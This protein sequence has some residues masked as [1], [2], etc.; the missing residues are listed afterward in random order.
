MR[1]I[2]FMGVWIIIMMRKKKLVKSILVLIMLLLF[3]CVTGI[4]I[5]QESDNDDAEDSYYD[6]A[7]KNPLK[8]GTYTVKYYKEI[9]R[10][11]MTGR[12]PLEDDEL[13]KQQSYYVFYY[14][15]SIYQEKLMIERYERF[16][17]NTYSIIQRF[18]F[19]YMGNL[20]REQTFN[21]TGKLKDFTIYEYT[22]DGRLS[23]EAKYSGKGKYSDPQSPKSEKKI[24]YTNGKIFKVEYFSKG[25]LTRREM[26]KNNNI[27]K[28]FVYYYFPNGAK[29][30]MEEFD[31]N[32][33]IVKLV[34][35]GDNGRP[36][37][38]IY[39]NKEGKER[40]VV[41]MQPP[42]EDETDSLTRE[43][44]LNS[45]DSKSYGKGM[46]PGIVVLHSMLEILNGYMGVETEK[47]KIGDK[48][49]KN[50][51]YT[52]IFG[53]FESQ[54]ININDELSELAGIELA[55]EDRLY[56]LWQ[57]F[58]NFGWTITTSLRGAIRKG[59]LI[60]FDYVND[61][62]KNG[63]LKD[64]PLSHVAIVE[65][66]LKDGTVTF[67]HSLNGKIQK[68]QVNFFYPSY[69]A[70]NTVLTHN[71]RKLGK[72]IDFIHGVVRPD[73][74]ALKMED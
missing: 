17:D 9:V 10:R 28:Q 32:N 14:S 55:L 30:K 66:T 1:T 6:T 43:E 52:L 13:T 42:K 2:L 73:Y 74:L 36:L 72:A 5:S 24:Y 15:T 64:D 61:V 3:S 67:V 34:L 69:E 27:V 54:G 12:V 56:Y 44:Y 45:V 35:Y 53:L 39:Y 31:G 41:D 26:Y 63:N 62:N 51:G 18:M 57:L 37:R 20:I 19:D 47:I 25:N 60:F 58:S 11:S 16:R 38:K 22:E 59:D 21:F 49:Y 23:R 33:T 48:E 71:G 65:E 40:K 7:F 8:E 46:G 70:T 68:G 50:N 4:L 29:Q